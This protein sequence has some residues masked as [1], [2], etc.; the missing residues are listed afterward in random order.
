MNEEQAL[1]EEMTMMLMYL[2]S[3]KESSELSLRTKRPL[4]EGDDYFRRSWRGYPFEALNSLSE[5]GFISGIHAKQPVFI[6]PEGERTAQKLL[7]KYGMVI[8]KE[9]T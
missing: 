3:W 1:I 9:T 5:K 7:I 2:T 4:K 8:R 6:S